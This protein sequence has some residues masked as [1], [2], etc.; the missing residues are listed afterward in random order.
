VFATKIENLNALLALAPAPQSGTQPDPKGQMIQMIGMF[1]IM[2]F[3]F[4]FLLIRPQQ[5]KAKDQANLLKSLKSGDRV[6]TAS[7]L[8]AIVITVKE[9]TV[10]LKSADSKLEVTKASIT[11]IVERSGD[12][13]ES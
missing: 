3:I 2:G 7:G 5:K 13:S 10:T 12:S 11:D 1:A 4:Y 8:V 6:I 9:K